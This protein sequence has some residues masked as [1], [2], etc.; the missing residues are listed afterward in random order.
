MPRSLDLNRLKQFE[1][2]S[3]NIEERTTVVID[4]GEGTCGGAGSGRWQTTIEM[5]H[6]V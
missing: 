1:Q 2:A 4:G 5:G 6:G 3:P